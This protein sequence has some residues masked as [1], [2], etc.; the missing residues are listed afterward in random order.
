M[1][2]D[3]YHKITLIFLFFKIHQK[4]IL[5]SNFIKKSIHQNYNMW[6]SYIDSKF[7]NCLTSSYK[8]LRYYDN[9]FIKLL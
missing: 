7:F 3:I 9:L 8:K 2:Y 1:E 4:H 5:N 6:I